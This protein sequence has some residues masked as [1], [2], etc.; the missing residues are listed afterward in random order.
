M[1]YAYLRYSTSHQDEVEQRFALDE[2]ASSHGLTIDDLVK[3]EGISGGVS[4]RERNLYKLVKKMNPGDILITTEISRL[5]RAMSD[6]NKLLNDELKPRKL[7]LIVV[8]MGLDL[9]CSNLKAVDEM[10]IF[11]FGF[12]AQCEKEMIQQRTQSAIDARKEALKKDGGFF[13]KSGRWCSHL[14]NAKG[15]DVTAASAVASRNRADE[16][17]AWRESNDGYLWIKRQVQKGRKQKDILREFNEFHEMGLAGF[18]TREGC[19]MNVCT[20]S[21]W[22][23][24]IKR[25]N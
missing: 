9:D 25:K 15:V 17:R 4:Y 18:S 21:R 3:D 6:I 19:A 14:G 23:N 24:E 22:I 1:V 10:I 7:R 8:K 20:L 11:A 16:A 2:Y 12:S 13:S 5:G